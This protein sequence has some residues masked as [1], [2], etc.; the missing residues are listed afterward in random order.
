MT[1]AGA[2]RKGFCPLFTA[3]GTAFIVLCTF[4]AGR[5]TDPVILMLYIDPGMCLQFAMEEGLS[6]LL[7][8]TATAEVVLCL[9][10]AGCFILQILLIRILLSK[11]MAQGIISIESILAVCHLAVSTA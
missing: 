5:I 4:R 9:G 11:V 2:H 1:K 8:A 7:A 3:Y 10:G 6:S